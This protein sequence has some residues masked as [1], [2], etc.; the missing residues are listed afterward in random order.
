[1]LTLST[2]PNDA[3]AAVSSCTDAAGGK[4]ARKRV[5]PAGCA[6]SAARLACMR[7]NTTERNRRP[8]IRTSSLAYGMGRRD[9]AAQVGGEGWGFRISAIIIYWR[10]SANHSVCY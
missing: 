7:A 6:A 4:L 10:C 1:M 2:S 3:N 8:L 9:V 5:R